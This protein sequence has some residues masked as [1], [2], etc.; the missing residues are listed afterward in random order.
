MGLIALEQKEPANAQT[1][2]IEALEIARE[3]NDPSLETRALNNL[4]LAEQSVNR[5]YVI[6]HQYYEQSYRIARTI[7]DRNAECFTLVNLGY[8]SGLQG[9]FFAARS[10]HERAL[11]AA[12]E[13]GNLNLEITTLINLSAVA[14]NQNEASSAL[15]YAQQ[16]AELAAKSFERVG[17]AWAMLYMGHAY[18]LQN[19]IQPAQVAYR[20][21]IE[22]RNEMDQP[23]LATEPIAGLVETYLKAD[24]LESASGEA[25]KILTYLESGSTLDGTDEP[26]RIYYACYLL[27]KKKQ[28]PRSKQLLQIAM[29]LLETQVSKFADEHSRK[30]YVENIPWRR[31]LRDAGLAASL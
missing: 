7:G 27:L 3:L 5:N 4:A 20:R 2:L 26:L 10:Y 29:Q 1:Y 12:Q 15:Q 25:D 16:A 9:D 18:L 30:R 6:A 31:A 23:V 14:G 28:D 17:E 24:D 8:I 19:Q 13:T 22:L 21:S 11:L